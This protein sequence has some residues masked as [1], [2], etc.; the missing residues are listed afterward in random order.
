MTAAM[1]SVQRQREMQQ[2]LHDILADRAQLQARVHEL[3]VEIECARQML[4]P[5]VPAALL[6]QVLPVAL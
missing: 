5:H 2:T 4:R 6:D 3:T 1:G